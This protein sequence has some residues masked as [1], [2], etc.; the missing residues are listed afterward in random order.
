VPKAILGENF[1]IYRDLLAFPEFRKITNKY[2]I[3]GFV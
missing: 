3:K 1:M 2:Q